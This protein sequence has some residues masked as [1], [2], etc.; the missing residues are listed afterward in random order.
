MLYICVSDGE[1]MVVRSQESW[2]NDA[3][4]RYLSLLRCSLVLHV[5]NVMA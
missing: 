3:K 2:V 5:I 1:L 4:P